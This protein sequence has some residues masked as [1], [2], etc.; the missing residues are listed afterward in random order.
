MQEFSF[1]FILLFKVYHITGGAK[2][3][4]K[5]LRFIPLLRF[6]AVFGAHLSLPLAVLLK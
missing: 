4:L 3:G 5:I 6:G 2:G 1:I